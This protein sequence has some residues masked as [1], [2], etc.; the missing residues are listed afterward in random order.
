MI[1]TMRWKRL[2]RIFDPAAHPWAHSHAQVPTVL[3]M[4]DR[5]RIFYAD[6]DERGKS[7]TTYLDVDRADPMRVLY[8]HQR[9]IM[10]LGAPGTFDDEG[11]MPSF[12]LENGGQIWLYYSGWNQ[13][14][15]VPYRNSVGIAVSED[16]GETFR[17]LFEGPILERNAREPYI[18]VTPTIVREASG[19]WRMWYISGLRW[20][21][22][23]GKFEPVYV[24]KYA[25]SRNGIDWERPNHQCIEQ[26]HE[27][28]AFSHPSVIKTSDGYRMWYCY[29]DSRDYRDGAGAYRIGYAE[30]LDGLA[31]S[32][33]DHVLGLDVA[34]EGW[35]STMTSY[36]YVLEV[37][38]RILMFYNGNGFGRSGVGC[39]ILEK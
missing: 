32:R 30:S 21:E 8:H 18:A 14:V 29:R 10:P 4:H 35:D 23:S 33:E 28:E 13:G 38:G 36:P 1:A 16:G 3:T 9:P 37:D 17:R 5:L 7:F 11:M 26:R 31:W 2:G 20:V 34:A 27:L 25:H 12:V 22:I 39:A 6:R 24:I 19:L 15:T